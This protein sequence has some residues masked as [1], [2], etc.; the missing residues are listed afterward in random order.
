VTELLDALLERNRQL[1]DRSDQGEADDLFLDD[2]LALLDDLRLAGEVIAEPAGRTQLRALIRFWCG[3]VFR[4]TGSYPTVTLHPADLVDGQA[5][6]AATERSPPP[7]LWLVAGGASVA[8]IAAA[9]AIVGSAAGVSLGGSAS[10]AT[11]QTRARVRYVMAEHGLGGESEQVGGSVTFCGGSADLVFHFGL[12]DY[13]A[14]QDLEWELRHEGV[15][16]ASQPAA[17]YG[18]MNE[19]LTVRLGSD[20]ADGFLPGHYRLSL[21]A[22]GETLW[23]E[24]FEVLGIA[25]RIFGMLVSDVPDARHGGDP[26]HVFAPGP[27][28]LYL[29]YS[30]EGLCSGLVLS[31]KL[32]RQGE[33]IQVIE[34]VWTGPSQGAGHAVFAV[35][36]GEVF[37][38]GEYRA[39]TF[40]SEVEQGRVDF[41]IGG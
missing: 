39:V 6:T 8:V 29:R 28:V 16:I 21:V 20:E 12:A 7:L 25:P 1:L 11:P 10:P 3:T 19:N 40:V 37:P 36:E 15:E 34:Q 31:H 24:G 41:S 4:Y 30:H 33:Q 35:A 2:V 26:R 27:R 13:R 23:D 9:L 5:A 17:P 32:F 38:P 18:D 22:D 14:E